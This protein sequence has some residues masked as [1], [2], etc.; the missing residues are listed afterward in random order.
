MSK[1]TV[2]NVM[3]DVFRR[4]Y[5]ND[6]RR[7][8]N[9]PPPEDHRKSDNEYLD[10]ILRVDPS[11]ANII[12]F[13]DPEDKEKF[14]RYM[15]S[16]R[17]N[18]E[19]QRRT[20]S[21]DIDNGIRQILNRNDS[22]SYNECVIRTAELILWLNQPENMQAALLSNHSNVIIH[23][24]NNEIEYIQRA[25]TR[26]G[27]DTIFKGGN[28]ITT[29]TIDGIIRMRNRLQRGF[30]R[31]RAAAEAR[32]AAA[33]ARG[34]AADARA[35][36]D[37]RGVAAQNN[38]NRS[39]RRFPEGE[40]EGESERYAS[41]RL[42]PKRRKITYPKSPTP[43]PKSPSASPSASLSHL[44][45]HNKGGSRNKYT[46]YKKQMSRKNHEQFDK[47]NAIHPKNQ[48]PKEK[49][50]FF[51]LLGKSYLG[52]SSRKTKK[53]TQTQKKFYRDQG[54]YAINRANSIRKKYKLEEII[55]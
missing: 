11:V 14:V 2:Q 36:P 23:K 19:V 39:K 55:I 41:D 5:R 53:Y 26:P 22:L 20:R 29:L 27:A 1:L 43:S 9:P 18:A 8:P 34:A 3:D 17:S 42:S 49:Y 24:L 30:D 21:E 33:E 28:T 52:K 47:L 13:G 48:T 51:L 40:G 44:S 25:D 7:V 54:N 15:N 12:I 35:A 31:L 37:A 10:S 50:E 6:P 4:K 45:I 16:K 38:E 32:G 46:M